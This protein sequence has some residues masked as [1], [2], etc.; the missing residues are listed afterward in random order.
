MGRYEVGKVSRGSMTYFLIRDTSTGKLEPLPTKFLK[1]HRN[2]NHSDDTIRKYALALSWYYN[3]MEQESLTIQKVFDLSYSEQQEHFVNFLY[4]VKAGRHTENGKTVANNTANSY[5]QKVFTYYEF[6]I[7]EI[8]TLPDLKVLD[9][10]TVGY[11]TEVG[12]RF[13]KNVKTFKGYLPK[14]STKSE[15]IKKGDLM[16]LINACTSKRNKLLLLLL[17]ETGLRIGELLGVRYTKDIDYD[18]HKI[19]VRYRRNNENNAHQ[20]YAEERGLPISPNTFHLLQIYLA[21]YAELLK[22]TDYLFVSECGPTKGQ[23][24]SVRSVYSI[25]DSLEKH[26][27][28]D[29]HP[30]QLRHYFANE[31]RKA[32]WDIALISKSLGHKN[33]STTQTYLNV[34]DEEIVTASTDYYNQTQSLIDINSFL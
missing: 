10:V 15:S 2:M 25:F 33:I 22:D 24:L 12:L 16:A 34:D 30:H 13:K 5:L 28:V 4:W 1:H 19:F 23:P 8:E 11:S 18:N 3:Y 20:K 14:N 29:A 6:L 17:E 32:G 26:S 31:R 9:D 7:L 21:D 27:K